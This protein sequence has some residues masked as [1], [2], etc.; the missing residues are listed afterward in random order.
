MNDRV[1]ELLRLTREERAYLAHVLIESLKNI[2]T[3]EEDWMLKESK[4]AWNDY[5]EGKEKAYSW[6]EVIEGLEEEGDED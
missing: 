1:E 2:P 4:A 5:I 6:E 3:E